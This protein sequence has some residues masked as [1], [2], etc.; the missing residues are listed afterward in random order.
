MFETRYAI[1]N[2]SENA[3][4]QYFIFC[5]KVLDERYL[6]RINNVFQTSSKRFV[7]T[8]PI[9]LFSVMFKLC[10]LVCLKLYSL[11]FSI[12]HAQKSLLCLSEFVILVL[13]YYARKLFYHFKQAQ[14][15][16]FAFIKF[17]KKGKC[18]PLTK[19]NRGYHINITFPDWMIVENI[20]LRNVIITFSEMIF[21]TTTQSKNVIFILLYRK[22]DPLFST[23]L[24]RLWRGEFQRENDAQP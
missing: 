13:H 2:K 22:I 6:L 4:L 17:V 5:E 8:P 15:L 23:F 24:G 19:T 11:N 16:N 14:K 21:L 9:C 12:A 1:L 20:I 3:T 10:S 18:L 7:E